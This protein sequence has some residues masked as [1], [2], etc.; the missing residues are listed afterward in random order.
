MERAAATLHHVGMVVKD[1]RKC[2]RYLNLL[3]LSATE[4][5]R[6]SATRTVIHGKLADPYILKVAFAPIG[7]GVELEIIEEVQGQ[8][9]HREVLEQAGGGID[10]LALEVSDLHEIVAEMENAGFMTAL[11]PNG[12]QSDAVY[13]D[14]RAA[15]G[16]YTEVMQKGKL[17]AR[18]DSYEHL[19]E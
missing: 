10:H 5:V 16:V 9:I 7:K 4:T 11:V 2:S 17:R 8:S 6:Y 3:G 1:L 14:T 18:L 15:I 12:E 13:L 19:E